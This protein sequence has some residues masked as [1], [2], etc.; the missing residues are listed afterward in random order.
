MKTYE[1][2][3]RQAGI[4]L[5]E[6]MIVVVVVAIL[7]GVALPA[8]ETNMLKARRSDAYSTLLDIASRQEQHML[9]RSSYTLVMADLGY[10]AERIGATINVIASE[11]EY[12]NVAVLPCTGVEAGAACY[13]L[14]AVA[15]DP[16]AQQKDDIC[17]TI[18]LRSNGQKL[19]YKEG[20]TL[21]DAADDG[22][23]W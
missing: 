14:A 16:G 17:N 15:V 10:P 12:Y 8:Y 4:T 19:S 23:C 20:D 21:A 11:E 1:L 3:A 7:A 9:D 2:P 13:V 18:V 22:R 6:L 5:I